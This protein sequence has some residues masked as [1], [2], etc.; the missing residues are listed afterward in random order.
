MVISAPRFSVAFLRQP[1]HPNPMRA[2]TLALCLI[3]E[4]SDNKPTARFVQDRIR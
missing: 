3:G 2:L 1:W 4:Y